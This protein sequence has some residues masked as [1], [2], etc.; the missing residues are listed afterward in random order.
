M[1]E[2]DPLPCGNSSARATVAARAG[3]YEN[4]IKFPTI[5]NAQCLCQGLENHG[6]MIAVTGEA[7]FINDGAI[8]P[9]RDASFRH[10]GFYREYRPWGCN[11]C[12]DFH[13][14]DANVLI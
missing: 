6:V 11:V 1:G 12:M 4:E 7:L 10:T 14:G 5:E 3:A 8:A 9:E 2:R 13:V